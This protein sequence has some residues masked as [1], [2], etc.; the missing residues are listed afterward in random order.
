MR[1][2][3]LAGY[4]G[5]NNIGDEA[6]LEKF[7]EMIRGNSAD[8]EISV[9]SGKP[10]YTEKT[11]DVSSV[12]R[13]DFFKVNKAIADND[14][15]VFGG[16]SLLQDVTSKK[17]IYY[18][19]YLIFV[20]E[21][22]KKKV[23][24]LSQGIGPI[25]GKFNRWMTARLLN[26][27]D[28]ITVRDA[29]SFNVLKELGVKEDK[30][31]FSADPV[32]DYGPDIK[33]EKMDKTLVG[34]SV[35]KWK[36]TDV[37]SPVVEI[38]EK[39]HEKGIEVVLIPFHFDE[40]IELIEEIEA[41]TDVELGTVKDKMTSKEL[42][43]LIGR[44]S[45]LLGARLHSLIFAVSSFVRISAI[46]YDPKVEYFMKSLGMKSTCSIENIDPDKVCG[47]IFEKLEGNIEYIGKRNELVNTLEEN[48]KIIKELLEE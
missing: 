8:A 5:L 29:N 15:V 24:L 12:D 3:L 45:L 20:S 47:D 4:Y 48:K 41:R 13:K 6:I 35:R 22:L 44:L 43:G 16:G 46:S 17:S 26:R 21:L 2:I 40:D 28:R 30:T 42:Y 32:I 11:F 34:I 14:I 18:Y 33:Y 37:V 23:I 19:L 9:L 31:G 39:L 7:I 36:D 25:E 27:A 38:I 1:K 10:E